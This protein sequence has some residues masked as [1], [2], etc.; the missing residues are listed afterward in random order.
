MTFFNHYKDVVDLLLERDSDAYRV[1][2][3]AYRLRSKPTPVPPLLGAM[4]GFTSPQPTHV[5]IERYR[6]IFAM[7]NY[8]FNSDTALFDR[9]FV[10]PS[11][12]E[13]S[14]RA[15]MRE[16]WLAIERDFHTREQELHFGDAWTH[17]SYFEN[18]EA[19][20]FKAQKL[21]AE[22]R[23]LVTQQERELALQE[24]MLKKVAE[25]QEL[26]EEQRQ[27]RFDVIQRVWE[28]QKSDIREETEKELERVRTAQLEQPHPDYDSTPRCSRQMRK[29]CNK[30]ALE[31]DALF[32]AVE[33]DTLLLEQRDAERKAQL[34]AREEAMD[35]GDKLIGV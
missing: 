23:L 28:K 14:M 11:A 12:N 13:S 5:F 18:F 3:R 6:A 34:E 33:R 31:H 24:S 26:P 17:Q 7:Y 15:A 1:Q 32:A 19:T 22:C 21:L 10:Q 27:P 25:V 16:R 35:E 30:H 29:E 8:M 4:Y 20:L 2:S 9:M